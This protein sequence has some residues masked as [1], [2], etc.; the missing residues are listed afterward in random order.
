MLKFLGATLENNIPYLRP[1]PKKNPKPIY[2]GK[3]RTRRRE[4]KKTRK[5]K[6]GI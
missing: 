6:G 4:N 5:R 2:G 1:P 3:I